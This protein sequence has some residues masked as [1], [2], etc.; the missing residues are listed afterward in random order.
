[1]TKTRGVQRGHCWRTK[2]QEPYFFPPNAR[3]VLVKVDLVEAHIGHTKWATSFVRSL[4]QGG[5]P[6]HSPAWSPGP[7]RGGR[8]ARTV[9]GCFN[10]VLLGLFLDE[11]RPRLF[12]EWIPNPMHCQHFL[13][14]LGAF[15][16][17]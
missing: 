1:M 12:R 8:R 5:P 14:S 10:S 9:S 2:L 13:S 6:C 17:A 7:R 11:L 16:A 4:S 3:P 15:L